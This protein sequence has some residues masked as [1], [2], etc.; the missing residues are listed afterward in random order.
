[1]TK[2]MCERKKLLLHFAFSY[3]K[4][5]LWEPFALGIGCHFPSKAP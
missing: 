1:M 5:K 3:V 4:G 2:T